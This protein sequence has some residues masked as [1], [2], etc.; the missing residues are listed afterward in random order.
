[1]LPA[2]EG[3]FAQFRT[4]ATG[5]GRMFLRGRA[6]QGFTYAEMISRTGRIANL[7]AAV[8]LRP[9][10][11]LAAMVEKSSEALFLYLAC[12]RAGIVYLPL[13]PAYTFAELS[14]LLG[15]AEPA[16]VVA[17]PAKA[18]S[19]GD[20]LREDVELLTL[21]SDGRTGSLVERAAA[22]SGEFMDVARAADDLAA[23][24]YTSGTTGRPKGSMLTQR[25]LAS[26]A[27]ALCDLW[28]FSS[29]DVLMHALP[30]FHTHGL[31]TATNTIMMAGA[32]MILLPRFDIDRVVAELPTATIMMG[33]PTFYTRLLADTR[34]THDLVAHMRLFISGSAPL[35][36][37]THRQWFARTGHAIL[38]RYGMTETGMI[39]SN[40]C[41]GE[42]VAGTVGIPLTGVELRIV[43]PDTGSTLPP[44]QTGMIELRG[45]GVFKGYWRK[46][47]ESAAAFRNDGF[48]VTG[49]MGIIDAGGYLRIAGRAK[50]LVISGGLNVYPGEIESEIDAI[51][52]VLESAVIGIPHADFGEGV[53]AIVVRGKN[54]AIGESDILSALGERLA[55]Y[56]L[57]KRVLFAQELPRNA[58]GK[59]E[60][61]VLRERYRELYLQGS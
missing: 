43:G 35:L 56:K 1:M 37:E 11:R 22:H 28:H 51:S 53:T 46:P 42:R 48:F 49:D 30:L 20:L 31:F 52:G 55:K 59:V 39:A 33:V 4:G 50:D 10:D 15:D 2:D 27:R 14:Y 7:L 45:P 57:P 40:P 23:I 54:A 58:M 34:L 6:G 3:L 19:I 41:D 44:G 12:L 17:S 61:Q 8:G 36:A 16:C 32:S 24:L 9:G 60:K 38:E 5:S 21:A 13:N 25:N 26:N 47:H 18:A 29:S